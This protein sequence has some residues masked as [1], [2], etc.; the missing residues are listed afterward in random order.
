MNIPLDKERM[1]G[2]LP[3]GLDLPLAPFFGVMGTAPPP[4][5]AASP[6]LC[7]VQWAAIWTTRN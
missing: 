3:W 7:R 1:V 2:K 5:W 4:A 6:R